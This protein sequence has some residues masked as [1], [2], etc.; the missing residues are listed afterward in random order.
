MKNNPFADLGKQLGITV[1]E[2]SPSSGTAKVEVPTPT[3]I[4][5][6]PINR[7]KGPAR[8]VVR[9]ERSGR[10]GKEA[11]VVEQLG[12]SPVELEAW[13]KALKAALGC[14]GS[15]EGESLMLQGDH[16]KRLPAVLADRG[17]RKVVVG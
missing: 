7:P 5:P 2:E 8:A 17:V 10:G 6:S 14:G 11:T 3:P 9:M 12:L 13:L 4:Q 1:P 16:R 15:I